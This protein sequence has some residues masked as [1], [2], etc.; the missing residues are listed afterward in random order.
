MYKKVFII[1]VFLVILMVFIVPKEKNI[2][3]IQLVIK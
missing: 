2:V 1:G 3:N